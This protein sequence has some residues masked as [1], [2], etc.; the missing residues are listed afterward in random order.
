MNPIYR[1]PLWKNALHQSSGL[2]SLL[3]MTRKAA[4]LIKQVPQL[5]LFLGIKYLAEKYFSA[6][7]SLLESKNECH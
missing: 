4:I 1:R 5:F 6:S 2:S 3:M 7:N